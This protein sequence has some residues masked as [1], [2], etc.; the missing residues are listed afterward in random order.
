MFAVAFD[1]MGCQ[2][3]AL[4]QPVDTTHIQSVPQALAALPNDWQQAEQMFSRF[5]PTSELM[6]LNTARSMP[7]SKAFWQMLSHSLASAKLTD[8]LI[9]PT[10]YQALVERGY[11][12]SYEHSFEQGQ[13]TAA[14]TTLTGESV[15]GTDAI[16]DWQKIGL[17]PTTRQVSLPDS[18]KLDFGGFA[19]GL[20]AD[21]VADRLSEMGANVLIDAGGDIVIR[22]YQGEISKLDDA[23][24]WQV[25]LPAVTDIGLPLPNLAAF[26]ESIDLPDWQC[27]TAGVTLSVPVT[28][29]TLATSGI[30]YRYWYQGDTLQHH[31]VNLLKNSLSNIICTSV[32]INPKMLKNA[33]QNKSSSG[34]KQFLQVSNTTNLAQTLSKL[35]CLLGIKESLAWLKQHGLTQIG[36]SFIVAMPTGYQQWLNPTI[37]QFIDTNPH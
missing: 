35:C 33:L 15:I 17:D 9:T 25:A 31:L 18:V 27:A 34:L 13:S 21:I 22:S 12:Q 7:V 2:M 6:Q 20:T 1:A 26:S 29:M 23:T 14:S 16:D 4:A 11:D 30:D 28:D 24:Q 3:Q 36:L 32:L 5:L 8:G 19:K 37:Q 10:V